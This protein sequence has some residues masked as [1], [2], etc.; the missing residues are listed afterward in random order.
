MLSS[1][2]PTSRPCGPRWTPRADAALGDVDRAADLYR[3][4]LP[5]GDR[6]AASYMEISTGA[7][8]RYLGLAASTMEHWDDAERH[9]R[10]ALQMNERVGARPWL[11]GT[12]EDYARMLLARATPG[13]H[14]KALPMLA[15]A[16]ST[17]SELGLDA[18][19]RQIS[20]EEQPRT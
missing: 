17:Y 14:D 11:A 16:R 13:D 20:D 15:D 4:L 3:L 8:A 18:R 10:N 9:F 7:V 5:Y 1:G 12:Q 2:R 19:A 6:V